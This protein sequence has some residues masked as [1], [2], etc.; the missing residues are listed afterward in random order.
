MRA[1]LRTVCYTVCWNGFFLVH[2]SLLTS[3]LP[4]LNW[5]VTWSGIL[6]SLS[7]PLQNQQL[8]IKAKEEYKCLWTVFTISMVAF[9]R[10]YFS[11]GDNVVHTIFFHTYYF[12]TTFSQVYFLKVPSHIVWLLEKNNISTFSVTENYSVILDVPC[13]QSFTCGHLRVFFFSFLL[14]VCYLLVIE[15]L[16]LDV[17]NCLFI[18]I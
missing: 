8:L 12:K 16:F 4:L 10:Y 17:W 7:L 18:S 6:V 5:P 11:K 14:S 3:S 13:D 9:H 15:F 2:S 1:S